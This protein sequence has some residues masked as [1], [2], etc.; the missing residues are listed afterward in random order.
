MNTFTRTPVPSPSPVPT[1]CIIACHVLWRELSHFAALSKNAFHL[2]FLEQGLHDTPDVLRSELQKAI[3]AVDGKYEAI[4]IG[5]GL[6]SNGIVGISARKSRLVVPRGHDCITFFLGSKERYRSYFDT[7]PGTYWYNAGWIETGTQPCRERYEALL[8]D[9]TERYGEE[10]AEYLMEMEQHWFKEY[11]NAAYIDQG[12]VDE[13]A[14]KRF[15]KDAADW[16]G[17][18]YDELDG[19]DSLFVDFLS[20]HWD[21]ARFLV[22]SPGETFQPSNDERI[23]E[24]LHNAD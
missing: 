5:Y 20:G 6:C 4:L 18:K 23:L 24:I 19:D 12:I 3:D 16:L 14:Y 22:V 11:S 2:V 9:Y 7:H 1:Y 10:N 17:W 15:T 8:A 13:S 21:D